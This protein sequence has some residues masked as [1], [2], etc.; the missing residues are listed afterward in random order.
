MTWALLRRRRS[1]RTPARHAKGRPRPV[2]GVPAVQTEPCRGGSVQLVFA[3]GSQVDLD[4]TAG[5]FH[6]AARALRTRD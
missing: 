6:D 1:P 2:S 5:R 3:D 4:A